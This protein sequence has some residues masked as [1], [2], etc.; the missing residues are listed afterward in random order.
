[1]RYITM[2]TDDC[3]RQYQY[4]REIENYLEPGARR[5]HA[6]YNKRVAGFERRTKLDSPLSAAV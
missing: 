2:V 3:Y 6:L 5:I 4:I 1:M